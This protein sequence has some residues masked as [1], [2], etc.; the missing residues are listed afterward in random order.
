M[1]ERDRSEELAKRMTK[2]LKN[3][4][5]EALSGQD[6]GGDGALPK[7]T[8]NG[9]SVIGSENGDEVRVHLRSLTDTSPNS[10]PRSPP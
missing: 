10:D 6:G 3:R 2:S 8:T 9:G 4:A 7:A 1:V 5:A